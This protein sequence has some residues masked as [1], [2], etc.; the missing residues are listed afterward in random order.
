MISLCFHPLLVFLPP[1]LLCMPCRKDFQFAWSHFDHR[2]LSNNSLLD[3]AMMYVNKTDGQ[4]ETEN[5]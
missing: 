5:Q 1:S 3:L 2:L 4:Q